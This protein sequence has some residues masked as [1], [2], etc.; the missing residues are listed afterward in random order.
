MNLTRSQDGS[1]TL[2]ASLINTL[3]SDVFHVRVEN[4]AIT[5]VPEISKR[6]SLEGF[7]GSGKGLFGSVEEIDAM[8]R[9]IRNED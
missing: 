3:H 7:I 5:L 2:P 9:D 4:N 6:R 8:I 1:L